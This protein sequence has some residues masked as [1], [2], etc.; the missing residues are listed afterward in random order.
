[1]VK[2][3]DNIWHALKV[4]FANEIGN[5]CKAAGIDGHQRDGHLLPGHQAQPVALLPE[6]RLCLRRLLPAEGCAGADLQGAQPGRGN[7]DARVQSCRAT[8]GRSSRGMEMVD[9]ARTSARIGMLGFAFKAGTDD[10][11]ETPMVELIER[12][13]GKGYELQAVRPQRQPGGADRRQPGLHPQPHSAHLAAD[14]DVDGGRAR[15]RR[16]D[17]RS[18]TARAEFRDILE[19]LRPGQVVVDLVRIAG[20]RSEPGR[21]D[22][23]CW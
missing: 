22:G 5:I 20:C 12:L 3:T 16:D 13:I 10:L 9:G 7:A 6:A 4:A 19:R 8:S 11:R 1:M 18:A 21:Y 2:Y 15:F 17:R 14:G 23:I